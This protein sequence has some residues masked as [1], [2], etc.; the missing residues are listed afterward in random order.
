[1]NLRYN[2]DLYYLLHCFLHFALIHSPFH[3]FF[4]FF[5]FY[6]EVFHCY[7]MHWPPHHCRLC[8]FSLRWLLALHPS[9]NP[10]NDIIAV[11]TVMLI[12]RHN[13]ILWTTEDIK[14]TNA[15]MK[16]CFKEILHVCPCSNLY[17]QLIISL[18]NK[19]YWHVWRSVAD[20]I[21][22]MVKTCW[23]HNT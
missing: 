8:H 1:M 5:V 10:K 11:Q 15:K 16:L 21:I 17:K 9:L 20:K 12:W 23:K 14:H 3:S 19:N 4:S 22:P 7:G 2:Y 6:Q 18:K 13:C